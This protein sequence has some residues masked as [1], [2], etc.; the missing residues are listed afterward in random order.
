MQLAMNILD[1]APNLLRRYQEGDKFRGYVK[2]RMRMVAPVVAAFAF[3]SLATM[4]GTVL[5]IGGKHPLLFLLA[6]IGAP[7][8]LIASFVLRVFVAIFVA[9]PWL[10]LAVTWMNLALLALFFAAVAPTAFWQL[11]KE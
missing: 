1:E 5:F 8:I 10:L 4:V 6:M 3:F 9:L 11:D 2:Q 7:F